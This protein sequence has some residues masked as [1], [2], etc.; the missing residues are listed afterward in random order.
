MTVDQNVLFSNSCT[1]LRGASSSFKNFL[2]KTI[3]K[4]PAYFK[5]F[6]K[7]GLF[8]IKCTHLGTYENRATAHL[9][10]S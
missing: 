5:V 10:M 4:K 7:H 9:N 2:S 6:F 3:S 8:I 1:N